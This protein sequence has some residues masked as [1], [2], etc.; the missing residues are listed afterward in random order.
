MQ[1]EIDILMLDH[2]EE[3]E[4]LNKEMK[5]ER[6]LLQKE[7]VDPKFLEPTVKIIGEKIASDSK[8]AT[9]Q[10][11][12]P[13]DPVIIGKK[14]TGSPD[15][16]KTGDSSKKPESTPKKD[17]ELRK[18]QGGGFLSSVASFFLTENEKKKLIQE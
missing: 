14:G 1:R 16:N 7:Y 11:T 12:L 10:A 18:S 5:K 15:A 6:A 13:E 17:E 4:R 3:L 8:T 2:N 9:Q